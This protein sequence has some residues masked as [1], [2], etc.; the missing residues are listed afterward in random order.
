M[1]LA[2]VLWAH[3]T[4]YMALAVADYTIMGGDVANN[5]FLLSTRDD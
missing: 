1:L 4:V 3:W 5:L 2:C